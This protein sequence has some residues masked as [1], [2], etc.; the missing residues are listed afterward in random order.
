MKKLSWSIFGLIVLLAAVFLLI[1]DA[2]QAMAALP[3]LG[4]AFG[5]IEVDL[6]D[7]ITML[8]PIETRK[9]PKTFLKDTF[10]SGRPDRTFETDTV[11]VD[12]VRGGEEMEIFCAPD[13]DG[14]PVEREGYKTNKVKSSYVKPYR[15][16]TY[17]DLI[18]RMPGE[19]LDITGQA[20]RLVA[21]AAIQLGQDMADLDDRIIRLEEYMCSVLLQEGKI[22][23][24][25]EGIDHWAD[26]LMPA[27]NKGTVAAEAL[28][29]DN[30]S[31]PFSTIFSICKTVSLNGSRTPR[32]LI[33][34][35][36]VIEPFCDNP[37]VEKK[38]DKNRAIDMGQ[39]VPNELAE[40]V[41]YLGRLRIYGYVLDVYGYD[42]SCTINGVRTYM[43][44]LDKLLIGPSETTN[45]M[46]YGAIQHLKAV[47]LGLNVGKRFPHVWT[48]PNGSVQFA[49]L[50]SSPLPNFRESDNFACFKVV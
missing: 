31:N 44:P 34:G 18:P 22:H 45:H 35:G 2:H 27:G 11:L 39:I 21:R 4:L 17:Q 16:L 15:P 13:H 30:N 25:G 10:F 36:N 9:P 38:L 26:F 12:I 28:F 49:Q 37:T 46:N 1:P 20:G 8:E 42:Y 33:L 3:F 6:Y 14:N 41:T 47:Q 32:R 19:S 29:T 48:K 40:G 7:P 5:T 23:I 43:M 50:E 24:V